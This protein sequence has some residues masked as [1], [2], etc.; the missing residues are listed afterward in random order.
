[1]PPAEATAPAGHAA[2][3]LRS[4]WTALGGRP[5]LVD[6]VRLT[7]NPDGLLPSAFPAF[8]AMVA[9]V[10][11]STLAAAVLDAARTGRPV[12]VVTID[13]EHVA[14]AS[15]SERHADA[16][17]GPSQNLFA[18][19][20]R[21]Y[22]SADGWVRLHTNYPWHRERALGV[23]G[24]DPTT[25][26]DAMEVAAAV[27]ERPGSELEDDLAAAGGLG[28][29]VRTRSQW[30]E[31]PQ[32]KALSR[33]ALLNRRPN[34]RG[35]DVLAPGRV[36]TG[37]RVLDLTRVIAGPVA[38]RTLAAW[39][40]QVLRLDSPRLPEIPAQT[41][42]TLP[43]KRSAL[44]DIGGPVGRNR[45]EELLATADVLVQGYRPGALARHGLA[46]EDLA[47]RHPHLTVVTLSAW[48]TDGPWASRRGFDSLVQCPT[49]IAHA[50]GDSHQPGA[51]PA[52]V[53]DHATGYLAAAAALLSL[54]DATSLGMAGSSRVSLAQTADW[55]Y[56]TGAP[57]T[58][59]GPERRPD[60]TP[61]LVTLAGPV[62]DVHVVGPPGRTAEVTPRWASTTSYGV[63][64]PAWVVP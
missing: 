38:T 53:L 1:M 8:P 29:A 6:H 36:A 42:D 7:G 15:R 51:L 2:E 24:L 21:F 44:L 33:L 37:L 19:L 46:I 49:G 43:G 58:F 3:P 47:S 5:D 18:P 61:W 16:G 50:E 12:G 14:L 31:H 27:R 35:R 64:I 13:H 9:A 26:P 30:L 40:A 4:A 54:A 57:T 34:E 45:M 63:D 55:L 52:Q 48:G 60:P 11:C 23:L 17:A 32:G 10:C 28:F 22:E 39:G 25:D 41:V 56:S 62:A 20:S 59:T